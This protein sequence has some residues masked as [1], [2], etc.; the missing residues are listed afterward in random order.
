MNA[1]IE[2]VGRCFRENG[3]QVTLLELLPLIGQGENVLE[4]LGVLERTLAQAGLELAPPMQKGELHTLRFLR[5]VET[6]AQAAASLQSEIARGEGGDLEFKSSLLFDRKRF[7]AKPE[8]AVSELES[9][10][11]LHSSLKTI[12]GFANSG[13]G[14]LLI[15]VADAGD[16]VGVEDDFRFT[17]AEGVITEK[18]DR[19]EM[20]FRS[21]LKSRFYN[22]A[23]VNDLVSVQLLSVS[24]LTVA[25][26]KVGVS[27]RLTCFKVEG[28]YCIYVRR[29]NSTE[30]LE[31]YDIEDFLKDRGRL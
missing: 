16:I 4:G 30:M 20:F 27:Q 11:V 3:A 21:Q 25:R 7:A 9:E 5:P 22:G 29:G 18:R 10:K 15:G 12:C 14:V 2:L 17:G 28:R 6:A 19:W 31:I 8:T 13:G 23:R 26:V 24:D 1:F